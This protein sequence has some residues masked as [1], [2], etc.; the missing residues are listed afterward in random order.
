[1]SE[2]R[3]SIEIRNPQSIIRMPAFLSIVDRELRV[4]ARWRFTPWL[5]VTAA[6][7]GTLVVAVSLQWHQNPAPFGPPG[8]IILNTLGWLALA[9]CLAE[10]VRQTAD[11]LSRERREGTLGFLFLTELTG[12][13]VVIGKLAAASINSFYA[14]IAIFPAMGIA[15][16]AGG[17]TAGEFWRTQL[18]LVGSLFLALAC[19]LW[20]SARESDDSRALIRALCLSLALMTLPPLAGWLL[21]IPFLSGLSPAIA[22]YTASDVVYRTDAARF[23]TSL[24]CITA[25]G[26]MLVLLAG[27]R[28]AASWRLETVPKL[29]ARTP[30]PETGRW[31]YSPAPRL[32]APPDLSSLDRNPALRL[33]HPERG[34]RWLIWLAVL[35]PILTQFLVS[36]CFRFVGTGVTA[37]G[38]SWASHILVTFVPV[39]LLAFIAAR[40]PGR[41]RESGALEILLTTPLT[42]RQIVFSYWLPL[43]RT[44]R[45]PLLVSVLLHFLYLVAST[46]WLGGRP[47]LP[48]WILLIQFLNVVHQPALLIAACWVALWFAVRSRK[49]SLV[50]GQTLLW[51]AV[52]GW[53]G[54]L[55]YHILLGMLIGIA[56]S[57]WNWLGNVLG[58]IL[59]LAYLV[60]LAI[61]ARHRLLHHFRQA[62][63][64]D[65]H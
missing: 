57:S 13:D 51:T 39:L 63:A 18:A 41:A 22:L 9:L 33:T 19:G 58:S 40:G 37:V 2:C 14:L 34:Q 10:G 45:W 46:V 4:R 12:T 16:V 42:S 17:A 1:M 8:L 65:L 62:V 36:L 48:L 27:R 59:S 60:I 26:S 24:L 11:S 25:L 54:S 7:I 6:T 5:R 3:R 56:S 55:V 21:S 50:I 52:F 43:W 28:L 47:N 49:T 20:A 38:I 44:L 15:L 23:W 31:R 61:W 30:L 53:V 32:H 29:A 64:G 35:L